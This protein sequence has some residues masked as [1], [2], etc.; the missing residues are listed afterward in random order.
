MG[1]FLLLCILWPAACTYCRLVQVKLPT[2]IDIDP[3]VVRRTLAFLGLFLARFLVCLFFS[4]L[5]H[6]PVV[7]SC[8]CHFHSLNHGQSLLPRTSLCALTVICSR[9]KSKSSSQFDRLVLAVDSFES[10]KVSAS[11]IGYDSIT[12][13]CLHVSKLDPATCTLTT[14]T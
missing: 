11:S 1:N 3:S 6:F 12:L 13:A 5:D 4:L 7:N 10:N 14:Y 8:S 9:R 2:Y